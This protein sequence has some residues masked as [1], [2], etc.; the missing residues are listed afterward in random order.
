MGSTPNASLPPSLMFT[1]FHCHSLREVKTFNSHCIV[2]TTSFP[3]VISAEG[4]SRACRFRGGR[5]RD[6]SKVAFSYILGSIDDTL[7]L[8]CELIRPFGVISSVESSTSVPSITRDLHA[9]DR[10][11]HCHEIPK[12]RTSPSYL[13]DGQFVNRRLRFVMNITTYCQHAGL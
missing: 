3:Q 9:F 13:A 2:V 8:T 1:H 5:P 10:S 4:Q 12:T 6:P 7:Q 11:P